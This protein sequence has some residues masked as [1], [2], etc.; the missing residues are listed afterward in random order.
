MLVQAQVRQA[1]RAVEEAAA[2]AAERERRA[3]EQQRNLARLE[4][5]AAEAHAGALRRSPHSETTGVSSI[6]TH[7]EH[8]RWQGYT[9]DMQCSALA[10]CM[11][12]EQLSTLI[13]S[14]NSRQAASSCHIWS[15]AKLQSGDLLL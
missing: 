4:A 11:P 2:A 8:R 12:S 3:D 9:S 15:A 13:G 6:G 14:R 10:V 5:E 7:Q 1:R